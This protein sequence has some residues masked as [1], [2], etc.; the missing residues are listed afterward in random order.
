[1]FFDIAFVNLCPPA[2]SVSRTD[3]LATSTPFHEAEVLPGSSGTQRSRS[4]TP[5]ASHESSK[6]SELLS[7]IDLPGI[8]AAMKAQRLA[9]VRKM[10]L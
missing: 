5:G 6:D 2:L 8:V 9:R 4:N 3:P 10:L 1:M 7:G